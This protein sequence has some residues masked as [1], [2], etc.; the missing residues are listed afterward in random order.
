MKRK[1]QGALQLSLSPA[2]IERV[3]LLPND[4]E[5]EIEFT[6]DGYIIDFVTGEARKDI[7]EE[8]V[9]QRIEHFLVEERD[10]DKQ[11]IDPEKSIQVAIGR[12]RKEIRADLVINY[13]RNPFVTIECKSLSE[14]IEPFKKQALSYSILLALLNSNPADYTLVSNWKGTL[15]YETLNAK[16]PIS[17]TIQWIPSKGKVLKYLRRARASTSEIE[18]AK[19]VAITFVDPKRIADKFD[20]CHNILRTQRGLDAKERLYELCKLIV[21]KL[22]EERREKRGAVNRFS[23]SE[24]ETLRR[25]GIDE[26]EAINRFFGE[27]RGE[28]MG[29]FNSEER[30]ELRPHVVREIVEILQ[31][32]SFLES[33]EDIL[34]MAFEVFLKETMTGKELGEFF[35]PRE[36]VSFMVKLTDPKLGEYILD[37]ACG[38]GGFLLHSFWFLSEKI[39]R[40]FS[41]EAQKRQMEELSRNLWSIDIYHY[42]VKLCRLNLNM[43]GCGFVNTYRANSLDLIDDEIPEIEKDDQYVRGKI[44]EV[45][46]TRGGFDVIL[47]NPPFG[48]GARQRERN[49]NILKRFELAKRARRVLETQIP[50]IL[51][52]ELCVKLLRPGGRMAIVL[53]D[54][55]LNNLGRDFEKTREFMR[56]ET[57]FKAIIDL[58]AGTFIPYGSNVKP[59]ILYLQRRK[60]ATEQQGDV[61]ASLITE[62]GYDRHTERYTKTPQNDLTLALTEYSKVK[63]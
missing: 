12:E 45:L 28:L 33:G 42:L 8:R 38:T 26:E 56:R 51:F 35:T 1:R 48:S 27:V 21:I 57:I 60:E 49:P 39:R 11:D 62:V 53:P 50:Q 36:L 6:K 46:T 58:P 17:D 31:P 5:I 20:E 2:R 47:T 24:L 25:A 18:E 59:S 16:T 40:S 13:D 44:K 43:H 22:R 9:R 19:R 4:K 15:V 54:G 41:E 7:P 37:P 63:V 30:I 52:I 32:Y 34:G 55:I 29:L 14:E 10:W 23:I 61:F 3:K